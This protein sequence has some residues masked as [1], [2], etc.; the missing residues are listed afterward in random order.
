M[1]F[2]PTLFLNNVDSAVLFPHVY[3]NHD[4]CMPI[5]FSLLPHTYP[6]DGDCIVCLQHMTQLTHE[7]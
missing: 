7:N 5:H 6:E 3:F 1:L 2:P 4:T